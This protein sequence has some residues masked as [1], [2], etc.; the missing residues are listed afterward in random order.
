M[1]QHIFKIFFLFIAITF[2]NNN[3]AATPDFDW[4]H[5]INILREAGP[6]SPQ[7]GIR[8]SL[9]SAK[10][11]IQVTFQLDASNDL[12]QGSWLGGVTS[13][14][15]F[16]V[17][18]YLL[19]NQ[20]NKKFLKMSNA[21]AFG[22][23]SDR[24]IWKKGPA[25]ENPKMLVFQ[26][27]WENMLLIKNAKS[28]VLNYAEYDTPKE[29]RDIIFPLDNFNSHLE[30]LEASIKKVNG[31]ERFLM[32]LEE[33]NNTPIQNLPEVIQKQWRKDLIRVAEELEISIIEVKK[34]SMH[35]LNALQQKK[36]D[37]QRA[38]LLAQKKKDHQAIY[39]QEPDWL[40]INNCPNSNISQ[41]KN[42]GKQAYESDPM[43]GE[44][45][46]FGT[47]L[48]VVWRSKDSIVRIYGGITDLG[49]DP[50]IHRATTAEYY[51]IVKSKRGPLDIRPL[52]AVTVKN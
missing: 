13:E 46:H 14:N 17:K 40:D 43:I 24:G 8:W 45:F 48:G 47:I 25:T 1:K 12:K 34:H 26:L 30:P 18:F 39:D 15:K 49:I 9:A 37:E 38:A 3:F 21:R 11:S 52:R 22:P 32:T 42:S 31:G 28:L 50:E 27:D 7:V 20:G 23:D 4:N 16:F 29:Y 6:E 2:S 5:G 41:C 33:I 19:D 36:V 10:D 35:G 44:P 51:Y